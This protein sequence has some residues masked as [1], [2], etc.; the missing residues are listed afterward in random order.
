MYFVLC[1]GKSWVTKDLLTATDKWSKTR[2]ARLHLS[3]KKYI[4]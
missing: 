2:L 3:Y 1:T 4:K